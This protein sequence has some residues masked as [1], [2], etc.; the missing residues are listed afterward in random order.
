MVSQNAMNGFY[1]FVTLITIIFWVYWIWAMRKYNKMT[2]ELYDKYV[3]GGG[4]MGAFSN[5][6]A[7]RYPAWTNVT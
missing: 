6:R 4:S 5:T 7:S 2:E 1:V 3:L